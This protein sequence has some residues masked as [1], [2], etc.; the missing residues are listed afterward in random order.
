MN[1]VH[2]LLGNFKIVK[3]VGEG[4]F[5]STYYTK[6]TDL[7]YPAALKIFHEKSNENDIKKAF[8]FTKSIMHPFI[9]QD[10]DLIKNQKGDNCLLMEYV[11]GTSLLNYITLNAPLSEYDIQTIFGQLVITLDFLHKHQIIHKDLRCENIMID[12]HKN[13]RLIDL[14]FSYHKS[15][16]HSAFYESPAYVSPEMINNQPYG[17]PT[18]IWSL[19][20]IIYAV[21]YGKLPFESQNFSLLFNQINTSEPDFPPDIKISDN[22]IDIIKKMLIKD[23]N[24]RITINDIKKHPFFTF[25]SKN[26]NFIFNQQR[27][28]SFIRDPYS[29]MIP[30]ITILTKMN[31]KREDLPN[32]VRNIK[33]GQINA[34]SLTYNI[35]Y[36]NFISN[37]KLS[38]YS[39]SFLC[40]IKKFDDLKTEESLPIPT[41]V[42]NSKKKK[43]P[44]KNLEKVPPMS[45]FPSLKNS[46]NPYTSRQVP[47]PLFANNNNNIQVRRFSNAPKPFAST[48]NAAILTSQKMKINSKIQ[49]EKDLKVTSHALPKLN[50]TRSNSNVV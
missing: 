24:K 2:P 21:S 32:Y 15:D 17:T 34:Q 33:S 49:S 43:D 18:D 10:F 29:K 46:T 30:E 7:Q 36:K 27:I 12:I 23:P 5:A 41:N 16:L 28:N 13:I 26:N 37:S 45:P 25:D 11:D 14:G 3:K 50:N 20:V 38:D 31:I 48:L 44:P 8:E 35:L 6:N 4:S 22:L 42:D 1:I 9:C 47:Y 19:G 39:R 40:P